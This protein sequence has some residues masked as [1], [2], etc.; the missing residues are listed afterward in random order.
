MD[1]IIGGRSYDPAPFAGFC[2]SRGVEPGVAW[3]VGKILECGGICALPKGRS[4][5]AT[6]RKE[7]FDL[8]PLSPAERCTPLSVAAHTLYEKTRPDRLP[9]PGGYLDL[10]TAKYEQVTPKICR[11]SGAKFVPVPYQVKMEGVQHL[12]YRTIFIGG[13]RDSILISQIDDF[14]ERVRK[15]TQ[16]LFPGLDKSEGFR[17][18][19]HVY[20]KNGVMGPL[21]P[22]AEKVQPHEVAVLGE[23][24]APTSELSHTVAQNAR[25]S[26]LHFAYEDQKA[27]TGNFACP[28]APQEQNAGAVFKF[29]VYHLMDILGGEELSLFP[30]KTTRIEKTFE[31]E[32]APTLSEERMKELDNGK[33]APLSKMVVPSG[34]API[35]QLARIVRSKNS[36]PF[37]ITFDIMFDSKD[38]YE[39]VKAADVLKNDTIRRLYNVSDKAILTNMYFEPALAW[40]CTIA[41][42]WAQGSVG[43][44]DTLGTQQH[45]PLLDVRVPGVSS[46]NGVKSG[47][48]SFPM[49]N[50]TNFLAKDMVQ[51]VWEGLEL[52]TET[53]ASLQLPDDSATPTLPSSFK[54]G[55]LAQG[56]IALSAL[57]AAQIHALR[58]KTAVPT[59]TVPQKHATVE[60]KSERLYVL[61]NK[62]TPSPWGPIGGLHKTSDGYVR[63]HDSFP[64]HANGT[65]NLMGLPEGSSR[66]QLAEKIKEWSAIDLETTSVTDL[67]LANYALRTFKQWDALP[68]SSA[69]NSFPIDISQVSAVGPSG[70]PERLADAGPSSLK[71]VRVVEMARVIAAP[72]AGKTLAAHGADVIWITSPDLPDLPTMDRDFGRGKRTA[73]LDI[74]KP[75]DKKQLIELLKSADIFIQGFRPEALAGYGLSPEKLA[76]INPNLVI[77]NM[78]A[79]GPRGPWSKRRGFDSL[80]QTLS[81]MNH[82][83]AEHYG[84][85]E[86]ARPTPCQALD[87]AGGYLLATAAIA[88]LYRRI[89]LGGSWRVDVSLAGCMKYLRSLGQYPGATGFDAKDYQKPDDVPEEYYETKD[90]GFGSLK[91]IK[92]SAAIEGL[93]VGWDI[94]PKPLGSDKPEWA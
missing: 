39:R 38:V 54:I 74:K 79:F 16:K 12:G 31:P 56:S 3:H 26:I 10:T 30:I 62:E 35:S 66:E 88:G 25:A 87:H 93:Y 57:L 14:L 34:E 47:F 43:E 73:H 50:R 22:L 60:Y 44:R 8:I 4:M 76:K 64:N 37:E 23:V 36:G 75:E 11:V 5:V 41:R 58:T 91:A 27:T 65:L 83:E 71:G 49:P 28:L 15:Y 24:V 19:Y 52:P 92:H 46:V 61:D 89:T 86:P 80:V 84:A 13:I 7:S 67:K 51:E 9:G 6:M 20:G 33:L 81:G 85:G 1:I 42:P 70:L 77:A 69:I 78:S 68:Q 55:I 40:K 29:S 2:L 48:P 94:M 59:V 82:S 21:E 32:P 72:L 17:L 90:S 53:L 45:A 18:I 63:V